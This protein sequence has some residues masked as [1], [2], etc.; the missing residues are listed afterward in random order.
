MLRFVGLFDYYNIFEFSANTENLGKINILQYPFTRSVNILKH[1]FAAIGD[2]NIDKSVGIY[3]P[4]R[5]KQQRILIKPST[6]T[7]QY[8][9]NVLAH[10]RPVGAA[11]IEGYLARFWKQSIFADEYFL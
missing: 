1:C 7:V 4:K 8:R 9:R 6:Y 11:A 3:T 2:D 10:Y 5:E